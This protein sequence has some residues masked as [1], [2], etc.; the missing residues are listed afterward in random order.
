MEA[1]IRGGIEL[2]LTHMCFTEHHDPDNPV[3]P[4]ETPEKYL[5]NMDSYLYD[6]LR[7]QERYQDRITLLL[8]VE[9]GLQKQTTEENLAFA[10]N[11]PF[12]FIIGSS[13]VAEGQ[14]PCFPSFYEGRSE[15]E[16]Y[17]SYFSSVLENCRVFSDFDVYGHLDYV[18]RY[19]PNRDRNYR[20]EDYR[21]VFDEILRTLV[22]KGKGIEVNT[23]GVREGLRELHP[24]TGILLRYRELGG[25]ILTIGSD[26]HTPRDLAAAFSQAE[27]IAKDCGFRYYTIFEKRT[28]KFLKF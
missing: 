12:D 6:F 23:S 9:L 2:G 8:G 22:A 11:W 4:G 20:Y 3:S 17:C 19:G 13:H 21:D 15:K 1:M 7:Y 27:T 24:A 10:K 25:E 28:P 18:V 16:A 5:L 26:A 14:D